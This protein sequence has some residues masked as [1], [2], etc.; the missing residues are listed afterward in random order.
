MLVEDA[1]MEV[2]R[3]YAISLAT[4]AYEERIHG[5]SKS[6]VPA[7]FPKE[8]LEFFDRILKLDSLDMVIHTESFDPAITCQLTPL[9]FYLMTNGLKGHYIMASLINGSIKRIRFDG[10]RHGIAR[11]YARA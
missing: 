4:Q 9:G 3:R 10:V 6:C 7:S 8:R 2:K 11:S 5:S 1:I